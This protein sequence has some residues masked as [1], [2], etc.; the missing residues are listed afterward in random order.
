MQ[1]LHEQIKNCNPNRKAYKMRR[2][3]KNTQRSKKKKILTNFTKCRPLLK[4]TKKNFESHHI[5]ILTL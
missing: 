1:K 3:T 2:L 4:Q 5:L